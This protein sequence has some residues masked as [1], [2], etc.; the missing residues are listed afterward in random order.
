[1]RS[2]QI[3]TISLFS[4]L[5]ILF[6]AVFY[7][8]R[9]VLDHVPPEIVCDGKPLE[10]SV[11][12]SDEELC[13]GLTA[14]DDI[15]G[16]LTDRIIVRRVSKLVGSNVATAYY[17]VFDSA[18]NYATFSR[19]IYYTDYCQPHF[20]L[21]QPLIFQVN[22]QV[23]LRDRLFANDVLDGDISA[24]IRV[25]VSSINTTET[26]EYPIHVQVTNATGD[27]AAAK[28]MLVIANYTSRYPVIT[29][30]DYLVYLP[31]DSELPP[32]H[33]YITHVSEVE[34]GAKVEAEA[35][36]ISGEVDT[37]RCGSYPVSFSYTNASGLTYTVY[38]TVIIE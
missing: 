38:L 30:S 20:S 37:A 22:S 28:L 16:D 12:A 15:D 19:S 31:Q 33:D 6:C 4:V 36:T 24:Q 14:T 21:E 34:N 9:M 5:A 23:T 26:G 35:V 25:G 32:L 17:A 3:I 1:M 29:L 27:T 13:A 7:R 2:L 11:S 10:V 18:S 8:D